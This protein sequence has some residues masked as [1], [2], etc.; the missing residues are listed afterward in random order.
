MCFICLNSVSFT[1]EGKKTPAVDDVSI[2]FDAGESVAIVGLNGSGKSTLARLMVGLLRP[3][4]GKITL[5][6]RPIEEYSLP[7]IGRKLGFVLQNP[8][9]MLFNTSVYNEVAF[10][11]KWKGEKRREAEH[12]CCDYLHYFDIWD[13]R[14]ELPFNLSQGQ[15]QIV[16][17]SAILALEPECLIMDEP[18]KNID[19]Y[20]KEKLKK[21]LLDIWARGTG[22]II[23]THDYD[24]VDNLCARK[25]YMADGRIMA[26]E[27]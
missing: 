22:L 26:D 19:N 16:V 5:S 3:Q 7:E 13:L 20:R 14:D 2:S 23:I 1:Y 24:F 10:G 8:S 6:G 17:L 15:K 27:H 21:L 18:T 4:E 12:I 9:H 25:I 11:L